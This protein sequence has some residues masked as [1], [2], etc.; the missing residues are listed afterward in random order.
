[1]SII[2]SLRGT[3]FDEALLEKPVIQAVDYAPMPQSP[4]PDPGLPGDPVGRGAG[5]TGAEIWS[6]IDRL[7]QGDKP[8]I[9]EVRSLQDLQ[10]LWDWMKQDGA[11]ISD[12]YD[13]TGKG[14]AFYL[15]DGSRIGQRV[16]GRSTNKPV[17]D[18]NV[19]DE[20]MKVHVNPRGGVPEVPG[21]PSF[22]AEG[23]RGLKPTESPCCAGWQHART[24]TRRWGASR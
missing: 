12:S 10:R 16:R 14:T 20:F 2:E 21:P 18:I 7:P 3:V 13:S 15:S 4:I 8:W 24:C 1:M 6:V 17:I 23:P 11:E 9:R 22:D 19:D 5:P